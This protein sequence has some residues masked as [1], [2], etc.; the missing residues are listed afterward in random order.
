MGGGE[1]I[2]LRAFV[3]SIPGGA[4]ATLDAL[5]DWLTAD[6]IG[7][8]RDLMDVELPPPPADY[9][10]PIVLEVPVALNGKTYS[11]LPIMRRPNAGDVET[12]ETMAAQKK[13]G[14]EMMR[15]VMGR[16]TGIHPNHLREVD[17]V[18][19]M[20]IVKRFN[21]F[22]AHLAGLTGTTPGG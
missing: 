2:D 16:I 1:A 3:D 15:T 8:L 11:E 19:V 17:A 12:L 9:E 7:E 14:M 18:D 20:A 10:S 21:S 4:P 22:F 5:V 6:G 13:T